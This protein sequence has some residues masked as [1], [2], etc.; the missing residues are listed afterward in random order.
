[1][2]KRFVLFVVLA[3][4]AIP[5]TAFG[6]E[7]EVFGDGEFDESFTIPAGEWCAFEIDGHVTGRFQDKGYFNDD[8]SLNRVH[9]KTRGT[10]HLTGPGG[11]AVDRWATNSVF[12]LEAWT[13]TKNGND[14]NTHA[15]SGGVLVN[16]SGNIVIDIT[17]EVLRI[18]G[19]HEAFFGEY[20]ALCE[21]IG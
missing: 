3:V 17:G 14:S 7:P 8:G 12:D 15:G 18:N 16:D 19:P 5:A 1:M 20:D 10:T 2:R 21:A 4:M 13:L 6:A 9:Q 11:T